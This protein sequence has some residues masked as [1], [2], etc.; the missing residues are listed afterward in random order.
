M[1]IFQTA[2]GTAS[3]E[4]HP[5]MVLMH[6]PPL[7]EL[8]LDGSIIIPLCRSLRTYC[9]ASFESC[10][11]SLGVQFAAYVK[12]LLELNFW[13][14]SF[15]LTALGCSSEF[16]CRLLHMSWR[17]TPIALSLSGCAEESIWNIGIQFSK[18]DEGNFCPLIYKPKK[19]GFHNHKFLIF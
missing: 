15:R 12:I 6:P 13:Y 10:S 8:W 3:W 19:W 16:F 5:C 11:L 2:V 9:H 17:E 7:C 1:G 14:Y 4:F 18:N